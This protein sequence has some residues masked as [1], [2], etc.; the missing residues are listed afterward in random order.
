MD[1]IL[2]LE[3]IIWAAVSIMIVVY[4][5]YVIKKDYE[6]YRSFLSGNAPKEHIAAKVMRSILKEIGCKT[7]EESDGTLYAL[8]KGETFQ[9]MFRKTYAQI[10]D[11]TW[12]SI[13]ADDPELPKIREAINRA[14]FSSGPTV[15]MTP[16]DEKGVINLHSRLDI[17]LHPACPDNAIFV[18]AALESFFSIKDRVRNK[19]QEIDAQQQEAPKKHRPIGFTTESQNTEKTEKTQNT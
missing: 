17:M 7:K 2:N 16:P 3:T 15:V 13:E 11:P 4:I 5:A 19:I 9:M 12:S 14:N 18:Q 8:Y 10:W 1:N 6:K